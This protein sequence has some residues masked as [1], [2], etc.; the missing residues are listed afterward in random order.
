MP[1]ANDE[2]PAAEAVWRENT[3]LTPGQQMHVDNLLSIETDNLAR[4]V[5]I[6]L[7]REGLPP[8]D[9]WR[10]FLEQYALTGWY[11]ASDA[12]AWATLAKIANSEWDKT[13][14]YADS[15]ESVLLQE[16]RESYIPLT[17]GQAHV[18]R[19]SAY[20]EYRWLGS[21]GALR[22]EYRMACHRKTNGTSLLLSWSFRIGEETSDAQAFLMLETVASSDWNQLV[23]HKDIAGA[24]SFDQEEQETLH[25][26]DS[27]ASVCC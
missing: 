20:A 16:E 2:E 23:A 18:V 6:T 4:E 17:P 11:A 12:I 27:G 15:A 14:A 5:L 19:W 1:D 13:V 24:G 25:S 8:N 26:A 22:F 21:G 9:R 3:P 10:E 7:K